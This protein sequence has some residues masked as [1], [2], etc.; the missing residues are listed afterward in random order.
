MELTQACNE[1]DLIRKEISCKT[2][3]EAADNRRS[4][5]GLYHD[6]FSI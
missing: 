2:A 1:I 4:K 6:N 5:A 3:V